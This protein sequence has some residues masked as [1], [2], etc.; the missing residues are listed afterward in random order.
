[1]EVVWSCTGEGMHISR[2][3]CFFCSFLL[4][5]LPFFRHCCRKSFPETSTSTP[6]KT[7]E[8]PLKNSG[9]K[10]IL[11]FWNWPLFRGHS[12][13]FG[14]V[15]F[16]F[17]DLPYGRSTR[18]TTNV[19]WEPPVPKFPNRVR[20]GTETWA[21]ALQGWSDGR[22]QFSHWVAR[23][24]AVKTVFDFVI[25]RLAFGEKKRWKTMASWWFQR[26][27]FSPLPGEMIQFD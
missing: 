8:C 9:W 17:K 5:V 15:T 3:F 20:E 13:V 24:T 18:M 2:W 14:G 16:Q 12:F 27:L 11:S 25:S 1:M 10:T 22:S 7:N 4:G 21:L 23:F 26:F 6:P 19:W